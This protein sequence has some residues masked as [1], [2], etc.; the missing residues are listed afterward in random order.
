MTLSF[1][2]LVSHQQHPRPVKGA[3]GR[4]SSPVLVH[5]TTASTTTTPT[6][7][8]IAP[9]PVTCHVKAEFPSPP[10][11]PLEDNMLA[12]PQFHIDARLFA[13][14]MAHDATE[15][16]GRVDEGYCSWETTHM[17]PIERALHCGLDESYGA[18]DLPMSPGAQ[19]LHSIAHDTVALESYMNGIH[20][21]DCQPQL[22]PDPSHQSLNENMLR[23]PVYP[24]DYEWGL[25]GWD[26]S[27]SENMA[28]TDAIYGKQS[29]S[30]DVVT[31]SPIITDL[32]R[33]QAQF[34]QMSTPVSPANVFAPP[35]VNDMEMALHP[36]IQTSYELTIPPS[37]LTPP[38]P[39]SPEDDA[40]M[41]TVVSPTMENIPSSPMSPLT[42]I[43]PEHLSAPSSPIASPPAQ[44]FFGELVFSP[45]EPTIKTESPKSAKTPRHRSTS[46]IST[47]SSFGDA[48]T[49]SFSDID[50][51]EFSEGGVCS[52]TKTVYL[53]VNES[54]GC[55]DKKQ[56]GPRGEHN[57]FKCVC[58]KLFKKLYN[59]KNHYKQHQK[60]K[61]YVCEVC[62]R[63][64]M[65]KHDLKR[66]STTHL[67]NFKPYSCEDCKTT[68]T[69]L[70]AL[71]RHIKAKRCKGQ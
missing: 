49:S 9:K 5:A 55:D 56:K 12:N 69:R 36:T 1:F 58:G 37:L 71:H 38:A 26:A 63:G 50:P 22:L 29:G 39:C 53:F 34:Y 46:S 67:E 61:P 64:F 20:L 7:S 57:C 6:A 40:P 2:P 15:A 19:H 51:E 42:P 30:T 44:P 48:S 10:C 23:H 59:L 4:I 32:P 13:P 70:D 16:V 28:M 43:S 14:L 27:N 54:H 68:F 25:S 21:S 41:P 33:E 65:R 35:S 31:N 11:S 24:A 8:P 47:V 60:D 62:K 45:S 66:H 52:D 3:A 17:S 18:V